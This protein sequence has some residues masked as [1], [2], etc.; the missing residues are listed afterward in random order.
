[1]KILNI[2]CTIIFLFICS[3]STEK[4][5][6]LVKGTPEYELALLLSEKFPVLHPDNNIVLAKADTFKIYA[7][8]VIKHTK[9]H[10]KDI[11]NEINTYSI[12][13]LR[14]LINNNTEVLVNN[15]LLSASAIK[16]GFEMSQTEFENLLN[17]QY[18]SRG[19]KDNF[20]KY[21][22]SIGLDF[23]YAKSSLKKRHEVKRYLDSMV[24][25]KVNVTPEEIERAIQEDHLATFRHILLRIDG[26]NEK[27]KLEVRKRLEE[28]LKRARK[29]EDFGLLAQMYS[30]EES[31]KERGGIYIG[32]GRDFMD[33]PFSDSL[34]SVKP[35]NIS[36]I[37]E[38]KYGYHIIK[39]IERQKDSRSISEIEESLKRKKRVQEIQ[40][41]VSQLQVQENVKF[42]PI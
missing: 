24:E 11:L 20:I 33:K 22:E 2:I 31:S 15:K 21:I 7:S 12:P 36:N 34:F 27:E 6:T 17:A 40:N 1:M 26:K 25:G 28:I 10:K 19:G 13:D 18:E 35:G 5:E 39:V 42:F 38:T 14:D 4:K 41:V 23:E 8:Q 29:G 3:C 16:N 37:V 9:R 32:A 30:E